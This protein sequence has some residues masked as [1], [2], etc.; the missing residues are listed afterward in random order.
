MTNPVLQDISL[1]FDDQKLGKQNWPKSWES[2]LQSDPF[3]NV[4][5]E[6]NHR[7]GSRRTTRSSRSRKDHKKPKDNANPG[8]KYF[9]GSS[10][11]SSSNAH[12]YGAVH[13]IPPQ[14]GIPGFQRMTVIKFF[15]DEIGNYDPTQAWGYEGC[16]LPG[17]RIVIGRWFDARS[18]SDQD[19][20]SGP[21]I[22]WNVDQ[23]EAD[24]PI[25]GK[26]ALEFFK[27]MKLHGHC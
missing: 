27:L 5:P 25:D 20:M 11:D 14:H 16:V 4:V 6:P 10:H 3:S 2:V 23:S 9:Y 19:V 12:L 1:F 13:G 15:P 22:F 26:K 18:S 24:A 17:G 21:F 7:H 8:V